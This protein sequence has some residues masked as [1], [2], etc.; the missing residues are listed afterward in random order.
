MPKI[1]GIGFWLPAERVTNDDLASQLGRSAAEIA[2]QS[3]V[4]TR[5]Y[6]AAG[7]GPSDLAREAAQKALARAGWG[8][9]DVEFLIFATMT[10]DV[11]FPGSGCYLQNK[12]GCGTI[13]AL[14]LRAQCTGFLFALEVAEQFLRAGAYRRILVAAGDVHSSGL[15]F[16]PRGADVTPLFGD[17]AAAVV[18]DA[19][20]EGLVH[21]VLHTDATSFERFWCEF[22][23]SRR[24]PVRFMPGDLNEAR[25]YPQIDADAVKRDGL[26]QIRQAVAEVHEASGVAS[27]QVKRYFLDHVFP[28]VAERAGAELGVAGRLSVS[29]RTEGHVASAAL[30]IALGRAVEAGEVGPG[31]LVCLAAA[32]AG[33]NWGAALI[34]L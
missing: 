16:S 8:P 18:I 34:R 5:Y 13:G 15:D 3:G 33:A 14:D 30:P 11:T 25:H 24:L 17:G 22:P 6:A 1:L 7:Q 12:L 21:S 19:E 31:D 29:G 9:S 2:K 32:G 26:A 20:G 23:C 10:P 4:A 27:S 28:E